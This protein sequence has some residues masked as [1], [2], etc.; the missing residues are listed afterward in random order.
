ML[1][2]SQGIVL[3]QTYHELQETIENRKNV[4]RNRNLEAQL[5]MILNAKE[6]YLQIKLTYEDIE[7]QLLGKLLERFTDL[8]TIVQTAHSVSNKPRSIV[9]QNS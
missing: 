2:R 5:V 4:S 7:A 3:K 1:S 9:A 6:V 8:E